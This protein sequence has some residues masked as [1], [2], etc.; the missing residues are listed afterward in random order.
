MQNLLKLPQNQIKLVGLDQYQLIV[1]DVPIL[2]GEWPLI[3]LTAE[4][5][6]FQGLEFGKKQLE[7]NLHTTIDFGIGRTFILT[8]SD[9]ESNTTH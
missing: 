4:F 1:N 2:V 3:K 7:D 6:N 9:N 8:K 5:H